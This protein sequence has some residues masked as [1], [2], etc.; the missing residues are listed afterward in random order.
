MANTKQGRSLR[1]TMGNLKGGTGRS[2]SAVFTALALAELTDDPVLLV[3]ADP[4][5]GT[6]YEWYE[7]AGENWPEAVNVVNWPYKDLARRVKESGHTGHVVIDIGNDREILTQALKATDYLLI[8]MAPS[9]TEAPR[10]T[11]TLEV[12][13]K[14][15]ENR[16]LGLGILLN[17]VDRRSKMGKQAREALQEQELPVLEAEIPLLV[18]YLN[19]FGTAPKDLGAYT[20]VVR[21]LLEG[22]K[23]Q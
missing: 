15:T 17:R 8:P 10:L 12:A 20:D 13:V 19:A 23:N 5:N 3:D 18:K 1:I 22:R 14:E 2:T 7:D 6:A 16:S 11:P 9:G 4:K 21:E